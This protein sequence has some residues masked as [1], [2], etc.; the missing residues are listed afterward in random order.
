M[1]K[2]YII[3]EALTVSFNTRTNILTGS[4]LH[5]VG[6]DYVGKLYD[7]T[8]ATGAGLAKGVSDVNIWDNEW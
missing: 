8:N 7:D 1:K 2:T 6:D 3:P 5:K 4:D